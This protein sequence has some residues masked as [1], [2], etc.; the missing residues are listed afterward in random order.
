MSTKKHAINLSALRTGSDWHPFEVIAALRAKGTSLE[1]LSRLK[2][3]HPKA[4]HV[5]SRRSW[6]KGELIIAEQIGIEPSEIWPSRYESK[7][8]GPRDS[9]L[10]N[11]QNSN[12]DDTP[13]AQRRNVNA[14]DMAVA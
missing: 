2:G 1:R 9:T 6:P 10:R 8:R 13:I 7:R 5:V 3:Y 12:A 11:S 14:V 4:L